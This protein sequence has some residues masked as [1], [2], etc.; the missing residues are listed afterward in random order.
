LRFRPTA[1]WICKQSNIPYLQLDIAVPAASILAEWEQV[2]SQAVLHRADDTYGSI[3]NQGW[4]S[5]VIYGASPTATATGTGQLSWTSIADAC[6]LT[7]QWINDT[8][9][10]NSF[11]GRIR[12]MLLEPGGYIVLHKDRDISGL[13]EINVA[14]DQPD[15]CIFRFKNYGTVPFVTGT[16]FIMDISNEHFVVNRSD[17]PRLHM[18]LHTTIG[19]QII[20]DSYANRYYN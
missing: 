5:L 13:F 14:I 20:K 4:K 18:I 2:K 9:T 3:T 6:P 8:F 16:A 11:T 12:F 19:E 17:K 15:D 7:T 1:E 10:I